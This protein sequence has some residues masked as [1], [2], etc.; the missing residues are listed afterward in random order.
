MIQN[1]VVFLFTETNFAMSTL[2]YIN[3]QTYFD[4]KN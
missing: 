1:W 4:A 2:I 3:K